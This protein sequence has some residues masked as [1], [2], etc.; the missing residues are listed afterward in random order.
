MDIYHIR[1]WVKDISADKD[2]QSK[3]EG[4]AVSSVQMPAGDETPGAEVP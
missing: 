3:K 4:K 2:L 1:R